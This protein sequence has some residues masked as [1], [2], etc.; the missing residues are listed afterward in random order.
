MTQCWRLRTIRSDPDVG[1]FFSRLPD[2]DYR[3]PGTCSAKTARSV[4]RNR[5]PP[6]SGRPRGDT[7]VCMPCA[8]PDLSHRRAQQVQGQPHPPG[9]PPTEDFTTPASS[10]TFEGNQ[11][12]VIDAKDRV[13]MRYDYDMLGN[14]IYQCSMENEASAGGCTM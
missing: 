6:A 5:T 4:R 1:N 12:A 9:D 14:R 8:R 7:T 2:A 10:L 11:R 13:V 3:P